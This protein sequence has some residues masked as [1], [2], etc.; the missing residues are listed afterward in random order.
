MHFVNQ[1]PHF[2]RGQRVQEDVFVIVGK[3]SDYG[4]GKIQGQVAE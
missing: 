3:L 2:S 1:G 4:S